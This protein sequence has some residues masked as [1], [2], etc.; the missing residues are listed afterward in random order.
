MTTATQ[1]GRGYLGY[2]ATSSLETTCGVSGAPS[3][4]VRYR[5][6][7][8]GICT[9]TVVTGNRAPLNRAGPPTR[10]RS[11]FLHRYGNSEPRIRLFDERPMTRT[12]SGAFSFFGYAHGGTWADQVLLSDRCSAV[13]AIAGSCLR[14]TLAS[15]KSRIFAC[16]RSVTKMFAG[17]MSRW[18]M[19]LACAASSASA[20]SMPISKSRSNSNGCL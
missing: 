1:S 12:E 5:E 20:T 4:W 18:I 8:R 14:I 16:P 6:G 11:G 9:H 19:P 10:C 3:Q 13:A 2:E 17:L 15:P 7:R